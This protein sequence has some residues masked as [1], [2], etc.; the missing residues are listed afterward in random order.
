MNAGVKVSWS[1]GMGIQTGVTVSAQTADGH[2][3]VALDNPNN[4]CSV[5]YVLVINLT[6]L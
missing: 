3:L 5:F 6:Q 4:I 2:I 1:T